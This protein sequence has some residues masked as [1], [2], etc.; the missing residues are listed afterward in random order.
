MA[1]ARKFLMKTILSISVLTFLLVAASSPCFAMMSIAHVSTE[2]ARELGMEIRSKAAGPD[3]V[4]VELEFEIKGELKSYGRVDLEISEGGKLRL[5]ASLKEEQSRPGRVVV[6]FS[7][8]RANLDKITLRVV[9]GMPMNMVG[10]ELRVK[11]FLAM[12][13]LSA[14]VK[15]EHGH[16]YEYTAQV[17]AM[18]SCSATMVKHHTCYVEFKNEDGRTFYIGSP[19]AS[20]EVAGFV[21]TLH[22]MEGKTYNLP[23]AFMKYQEQQ[24]KA[25]N[26]ADAEAGK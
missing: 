18:P 12:E 20:R 17:L 25:L 15:A 26:K 6:S 13:K 8:D 9:V 23:D 24:K 7:A 2:R 22:D 11:D 21:S 1:I 3:A 10:Y 5:F 19:G 16:V 4:R 14:P